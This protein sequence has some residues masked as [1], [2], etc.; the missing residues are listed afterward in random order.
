MMRRPRSVGQ[1][2]LPP[3]GPWRAARPP[4]PGPAPPQQLREADR[5][6][7]AF[8]RR[9][10]ARPGPV[11]HLAAGP[12]G[13]SHVA[14]FHHRFAAAS[15]D[16]GDQPVVAG[17][18]GDGGGP[19]GEAECL[20]VLAVGAGVPGV[21]VVRGRQLRLRHLLG[22]GREPLVRPEEPQ[23]TLPGQPTLA[24]PLVEPPASASASRALPSGDRPAQ[25]RRT[26]SASG[27]IAYIDSGAVPAVRRRCSRWISRPG[28]GDVPGVRRLILAVA[29]PG[30][31]PRTPGSGRASGSACRRPFGD[32]DHQGLVHQHGQ[33]RDRIA[34]GEP[35]DRGADRRGWRTSTSVAAAGPRR[36][37]AS[38]RTSVTAAC[39]VAC[40]LAASSSIR[41]TDSARPMSMAS[42]GDVEP[43][44]QLA[45]RERTQPGRGQ[46]QRERQP[47]E[48]V[49]DP[50]QRLDLAR[51]ERLAATVGRDPSS[52]KRDR[53]ARLAVRAAGERHRWNPPDELAGRRSAAPGSS[54]APAST[55]RSRARG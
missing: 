4:R 33:R 11:D 5:R 55:S 19:L 31:G 17:A 37:A 47:V 49:G 40:R 18:L 25:R 46:L 23:P 36:G 35:R 13:L 27:S 7:P 2:A 10:H 12:L 1:R 54:P 41:P 20:G 30:V 34:A 48:P 6:P 51:R 38:G 26:S 44:G 15:A 9:H 53:L 50:G 39:M 14:Q 52:E 43:V 24:P 8:P 3:S 29:R 21:H 42:A 16:P 28:P 22:R 45:G 32:G